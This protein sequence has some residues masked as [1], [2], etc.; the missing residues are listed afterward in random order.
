MANDQIKKSQFSK[1][2][3]YESR[4]NDSIVKAWNIDQA[5]SQPLPP[6]LSDKDMEKFNNSHSTEIST[7]DKISEAGE[8]A[9]KLKGSQRVALDHLAAQAGVQKPGPSRSEA[10]LAG[11]NS[12]E[13]REY[14][15]D[16]VSLASD[17]SK[18]DTQEKSLRNI[19]KQRG[20]KY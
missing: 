15:A 1:A 5:L 17:L 2:D 8:K 20:L 10:I 14:T 16:P 18:I 4:I 7:F 13:Y 3:E 9:S 11:V 19:A 12:P 6:P